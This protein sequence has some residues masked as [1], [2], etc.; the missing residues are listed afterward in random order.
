[1]VYNKSIELEK[2][3]LHL[4]EDGYTILRAKDKVEFDLDDAI[5]VDDITF[6]FVEGKPFVTLVDARNIRSSM[7]HE[8]RNHFAT[9]KK[10]TDIRKAQAIVVNNLHTKL[11][12]NFYMNFHRPANPI[13]IFNDYDKADKWVRKIRSEWYK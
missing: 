2:C 5:E 6:D 13:K 4:L 10:I 11:I 1:L 9:N 8:A 7:S 12:A 3:F